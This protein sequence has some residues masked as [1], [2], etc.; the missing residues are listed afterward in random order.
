MLDGAVCSLTDTNQPTAGDQVSVNLK[1]GE[2][3][4]EC[5][6]L[7]TNNKL[8]PYHVSAFTF[9]EFRFALI[10]EPRDVSFDRGIVLSDLSGVAL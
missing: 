9:A 5:I 3:E 7:A 10:A 1:Y 2:R 6:S 8:F 4:E